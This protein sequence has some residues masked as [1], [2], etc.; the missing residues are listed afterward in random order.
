MSEVIEL[1]P[2]EN[3]HPAT[4]SAIE[5]LEDVLRRLRTGASIADTMIISWSSEDDEGISHEYVVSNTSGLAAALGLIEITKSRM[6]K[7]L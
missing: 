5:A 2:S 7:L 1:R 4:W 3:K 6:T